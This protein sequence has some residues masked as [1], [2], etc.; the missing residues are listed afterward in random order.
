[1]MHTQT[2][3]ATRRHRASLRIS[4]D[5]DVGGLICCRQFS[6]YRTKQHTHRMPMHTSGGIDTITG[7]Q[8]SEDKTSQPV[9]GIQRPVPA[10]SVERGSG[11]SECANVRRIS[12]G[13]VAFRRS[14]SGTVAAVFQILCRS[15]THWLRAIMCCPAARLLDKPDIHSPKSQLP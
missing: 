3:P 7:A 14:S 2:N 13:S 10:T 4:S 9:A 5:G 8:R 11:V 15:A 6:R 12:P 1:M